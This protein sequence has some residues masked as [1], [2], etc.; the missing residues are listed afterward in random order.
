MKHKFPVDGQ[1]GAPPPPPIA[2]SIMNKKVRIV[3]LLKNPGKNQSDKS[4]KVELF[5][6]SV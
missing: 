2:L 1:S 5:F 6:S 3:Q 4:Y